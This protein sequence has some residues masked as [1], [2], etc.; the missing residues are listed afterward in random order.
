MARK[1]VMVIGLVLLVAGGYLWWKAAHPALTD[2]Q[3]I[4]VNLESLRTSAES[5]SVDGV[6]NHL[7]EEFKWNGHS[8]SEVRSQL[9]GAFYQGFRKRDFRL[10]F[11]AVQAEVSGE[12]AKLTGHYKVDTRADRTFI[13]TQDGDFTT[14]WVKKDGR[15]KIATVSGGENVGM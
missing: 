2:E 11:T 4:V 14:T 8:R 6:M 1:I 5:G 15:W 9:F 12:T 13:A 3:Q 10:S 7:A